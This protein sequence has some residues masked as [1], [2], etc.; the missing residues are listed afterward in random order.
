MEFQ[1]VR[2]WVLKGFF[3]SALQTVEGSKIKTWRIGFRLFEEI[4]RVEFFS[5]DMSVDVQKWKA[6]AHEKAAK[7]VANMLQVRSLLRCTTVFS[8][9]HLKI[10][11]QLN[12][13]EP[14]KY[15]VV[16]LKLGKACRAPFARIIKRDNN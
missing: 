12:S 4:Y 15:I 5:P 9:A 2:V 10:D 11:I 7:T 3:H 13:L 16:K 6:E 8:S 1:N 14:H